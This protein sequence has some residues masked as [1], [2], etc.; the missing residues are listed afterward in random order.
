V[1]VADEEVP[2]V[3]SG[4][5][6]KVNV[7]GDSPLIEGVD[8]RVEP[9]TPAILLSNPLARKPR[10]FGATVEENLWNGQRTPNFVRQAESRVLAAREHLRNTEQNVLM[11][12]VTAYM[13]V[14]RDAAIL[15]LDEAHVHVQQEQ[16]REAQDR[17]TAG[18]VT[19]TDVEQAKASLA[20]A[21]ANELRAR[22]TLQ[23]SIADYRRVIGEPPKRLD[24]AKAWSKNMPQSLADAVAISQAEHPAIAAALHG[25]DAAT[26]AIHLEE[27]RLYPSVDLRGLIDRRFNLATDVV[28]TVPFTLLAAGTVTVPIYDGGLTYASTRQAKEQLSQTEFG[29]DIERERVRAAVI[30]AWGRQSTAPGVVEAAKAEVAA[31]ELAFKG[32]RE[33]ARL[34]QRTTFDELVAAQKL[35][36]ARIRLVSAERDEVVA[37][38]SVLSAI[39]RLST[40][41]LGLAVQRYDPTVHFNQVKDKWFGLR[42]PEGR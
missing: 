17:Y 41:R 34:G 8:K 16:V 19:M 5:R 14:L 3:S 37:S 7:E 24:P 21:Q 38:Y 36:R 35:L 22:S 12:G 30:S 32:I 33:E 39:G 18:E 42:T 11:D 31:A 9:N 6:P 20:E 23:T 4:Y 25:V 1:R 13:D 40:S 10:G 27:G 2:K 29:A 26:L 15:A 28:P